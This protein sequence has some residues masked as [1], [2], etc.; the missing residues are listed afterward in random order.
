MAG[1]VSNYVAT[2]RLPLSALEL[3][4]LPFEMARI[5]L[6]PVAEAGYLAAAGDAKAA[7]IQTLS[8][9]RHL[10]RAHWL[11]NNADRVS[12]ALPG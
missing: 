4:A 2:A 5:P 7:I 12:G 6:Y 11:V 1:L 3:A 10:P 8:V 9:D